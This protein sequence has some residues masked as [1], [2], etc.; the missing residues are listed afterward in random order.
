MRILG[1]DP[2]SRKTGYGIVDMDG[3]HIT[4]VASGCISM[5]D[6]VLADRLKTIFEGVGTLIATYEPREMAIGMR[7]L[8]CLDDSKIMG[9]RPKKV[10]RVVRMIGRKRWIPA[11]KI[12]EK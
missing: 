12:A 2:G 9:N 1:I 8:A 10:V 4:Y 5:S 11:F 7:N 6:Q 3:Q